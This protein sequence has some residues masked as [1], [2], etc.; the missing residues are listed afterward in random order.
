MRCDCARQ[1][2]DRDGAI[3]ARVARLVDLA[4]SAG[5][6]WREDLVRAEASSGGQRH[7]LVIR[8]PAARFQRYGWFEPTPS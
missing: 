1:D 3:Q 4:H 2:L 8:F 7:E 5:A 6:D